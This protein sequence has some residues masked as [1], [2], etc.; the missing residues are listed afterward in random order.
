[1]SDTIKQREPIPSDPD[2]SV[3]H[4][5]L[6]LTD[7]QLKA[8]IE[9]CEY[10]EEKPCRDGCPADCSPA[11]FIKAAEVGEDVDYRR[12]AA[13]IMTYN[14]FG[15]VCGL[16]CPD[17]HCMAQC[18][19]KNFDSPVEIPAV[20]ATIVEK[21]KQ[22][23]VM[24]ALESPEATG[25]PVAIVGSGPAGLGAAA[26]L[27]QRGHPV[28]I[29]ERADEPGGMCRLIP[30]FRL[31][32]ETLR[33]DMEW[34]LEL[35]NIT[36][37]TGVE[38]EEPEQL[39]D[40][41]EAVVVAA[42][43]WN[44]L[45][46]GIPNQELGIAG[47]EFL[48]SPKEFKL[49]DNVA[50]IGGGATAYDC[51]VVA[52]QQGAERVELFSLEKLSE[53][54]LTARE[55]NELTSSG[56]DVNG[57]IQ[58]DTIHSNSSDKIV[59]ITARKIELNSEEFS[60]DAIEPV[61][62]SE[63]T[64]NDIDTVIFAIGATSE[65]ETSDNDAIFYAGDCAEGPT[66]VVEGSAA[67]KNVAEQVS[68][69]LDGEN[70]PEFERNEFGAVKSTIEI[71]GFDRH[72]VP[73]NTTFFNLELEHPFL[74]SA[75]P[76]TDGYEQM[77]LA[78]EAGW[79]GG[80]MKTSFAE[81][82]IH[83]P[84]HYMY[85][86]DDETYANCDNVSGHLL[87]RVCGEID[88]L[89]EEFPD[90][91]VAAS[92]GGPVTGNES[93]DAKGWQSNTKRLE[94]AGAQLIEY[95]LS[96]PQGGEGTEGDIVAQSPDLSAQVIEWVLSESDPEVPKLFKLTPAVTAIETVINRIKEVFA[97]YPEQRAGITLGN[98]FP[99]LA[100]Q[101]NEEKTWEEGVVAGMSG[102]GVLNINYHTLAKATPLNV[103]ISGN[104]GPM[105]YKAA[106]DFLALG[107]ETAQFC[108][109]P[110]AMGYDIVRELTSG[111]SH[112]MAERGIESMDELIGIMLP[113]PV[114]D[115]MEL[116]DEK[117]ISDQDR[118][119]CTQCGNCTRCPYLAIEM[120]DENYPETD[121]ELCIG[122]GMCHKLCP[123]GAIEMR[124]RTAEEA[125]LLTEG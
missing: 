4:T 70:I 67:G 118:D 33:T 18:T 110:T 105:N 75:A 19:H 34:L 122:C 1:M 64:R 123:Y 81:G 101:D 43:L 79:A 6:F 62:N 44:P 20:Q 97:K 59:G 3:Y 57:R 66:T 92:T 50:V 63:I 35:D 28:T 111:V 94:D 80:I 82:P 83:I 60:L 21:A 8:E 36:L 31:D 99:S 46:P 87:D 102:R 22:L 108:T 85:Q 107:C 15:G 30:E 51:A 116:S 7:A 77:K 72:P 10:C 119:L 61:S 27:A 71:P 2:D 29:F 73:L 95:S 13:E 84:G 74:L 90:K 48:E 54:P 89:Q 115:F 88:E 93:E 38:I 106:A 42:G 32:D 16:V 37:E 41:F 124:E 11:D 113:E 49:G 103:A 117:P 5:N 121:A 26:L 9:K 23:G 56:I 58:V 55:M 52:D 91:L 104:G 65:V 120:D 112:L 40:D 114:R 98:T 24:P 100:L 78:F 17:K 12:S 45:Y 69:Y 25:E 68:A 53:M 86:Y 47:L 76:P 109:M 14:P 96:C 125:E 39:L